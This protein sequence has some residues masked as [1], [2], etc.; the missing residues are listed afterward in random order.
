M[1]HFLENHDE[2]R[3]ASS[4][5]AGDA[6]K[7]KPAMVVSSLIGRSPTLLYIGQDV[8]E[9]ARGN[10]AFNEPM[11]NSLFDYHGLPAHQ[12]WMNDGKFDGGALSDDEKELRD[13]Y[14]RL[15]NFSASSKALQGEYAHVH[16][17]SDKLFSFVRWSGDEQLI[18]VSNFD[19][20][21]PHDIRLE[22]P[23]DVIAAWQL[24]DGRYTL[25]EQL[26]GESNRNLIVD[27]GKGFVDVILGPLDSAILKVGT[28]HI[29][30]HANF[31]SRLVDD[32]HIDVWLPTGY[33]DSDKTY[34][35]IYF[36]DGQ[37]LYNPEWV[38]Y[39]QTDWGIDESLQRLID[40]GEVDDTIVVGIWST[41]K[42]TEEYYPQPFLQTVTGEQR[43][44]LQ[45]FMTDKP[46]SQE[47]LKFIVE[48]LKPF[49]DSQY[50]T[51]LRKED[52]FLMGSSLGGLISFY[53]LV[54]YPDVFGGAACV[55][56]AWPW[57]AS[58][59]DPASLSAMIEY[60]RDAIPAPGE[61]RFYFDFGTLEMGGQY[62]VYQD[63]VDEVFRSIGYEHGPLWQTHRFEG[64]DHN[65]MAWR[66]R[67]H[68]PLKFLLAPVNNNNE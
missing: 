27:G 33:H 5:F 32:R 1:L 50:R 8:G 28:A 53:G 67:V 66:K 38:Y 13:F 18:V 7:G 21:N 19:D 2:E 35:V 20:A 60:L 42:R 4:N 17:Q 3:I 39:T 11:R 23:N 24:R 58:I 63:I 12:R 9:D 68:V 6:N 59:D 29:V 56:S 54:S 16:N 49:I 10:A 40:S 43:G 62:E 26:F 45:E 22:I 36:Q 48:E 34:R 55:S 14:V 57:T 51:S 41:P 44:K 64:V 52:T 30:R 61:Q 37:N 47:Y 65:E 15:M 46:A 25:E 31:G